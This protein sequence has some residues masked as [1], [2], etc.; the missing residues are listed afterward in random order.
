MNQIELYYFW[1]NHQKVLLDKYFL[2][3]FYSKHGD[4]FKLTGI[5]LESTVKEYDF[6]TPGFR[7]LMA[8]KTKTD[9]DFLVISDIDIYFFENIFEEIYKNITLNLDIVFQHEHE[10]LNNKP[11][12]NTGFML[13]K[14]TE[15]TKRF[16]QKILE[17]FENW[18]NPDDFINEQLFANWFLEDINFGLFD[19]KI[20]CYSH[21]RFNKNAILHHANVA[22]NVSDKILQLEEAINSSSSS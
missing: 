5:E 1:N 16:W 18:A 6:R 15:K 10:T 21:G 9:Q 20:W 7:T 22:T 17:Q 3:S 13:L 12:V 4:E 2:P 11:I 14:G 19:K 8:E